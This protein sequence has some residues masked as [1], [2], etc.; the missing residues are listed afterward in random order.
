MLNNANRIYLI[1]YVRYFLRL[2]L[3]DGFER[4]RTTLFGYDMP[5]FNI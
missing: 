4:R 2:L 5:R 3:A 1:Y